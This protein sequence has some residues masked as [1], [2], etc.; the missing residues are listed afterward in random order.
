VKSAALNIL[1]VEDDLILSYVLEKYL[2]DLEHN[3]VGSASTGEQAVTKAREL[4][5][6][7]ILMDIKLMGN[8]DGI[9]AIGKIR[10][11]L[12]VPVIYITGNSDPYN[13]NRAEE[14]GYHDYL[15]KPITVSDLKQSLER[16][17]SS[18]TNNN[19]SGSVNGTNT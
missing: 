16:L 8:T 15:I 4:K 7:L 6:D 14:V 9:E 18:R 5:P 17:F 19:G 11:F 13:M 1:I 2:A 3:V 12:N 10:E